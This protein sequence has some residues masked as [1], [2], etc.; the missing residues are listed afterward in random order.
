MTTLS[1]NLKRLREHRGFT[2]EFVAKYCNTTH[3]AVSQW[4]SDATAYVPKIDKLIALAGLYKT[5][6]E[7]MYEN[8]D[9]VPGEIISPVLDSVILEKV[10]LSLDKSETI[11]YAFTQASVKRRAYFFTLLYSLCEEIDSNYL[12]ETE[13]TAL[14][15]I[16]N[17]PKKTKTVKGA[18]RRPAVRARQKTK[19]H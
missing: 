9:L 10:F 7:E 3:A 8:P 18:G 19:K 2:K 13:V 1:N 17:E 5:T 16:K 14:M 12:D 11:S 4:E 6:V 15:D